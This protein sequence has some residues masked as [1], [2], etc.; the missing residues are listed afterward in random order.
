MGNATR[1]TTLK[2]QTKKT[3]KEKKK[4]D[5]T[6]ELESFWDEAS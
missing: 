3:K 1:G 4:L 5:N 6:R 2:N